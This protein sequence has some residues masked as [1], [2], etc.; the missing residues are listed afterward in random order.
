MRD[1]Y[2]VTYELHIISTNYIYVTL[3]LWFDSRQE[4]NPCGLSEHGFDTLN[5]D[6]RVWKDTLFKKVTTTIPYISINPRDLLSSN[7]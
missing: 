5:H 6:M 1:P 3:H 7:R 4:M 2:S